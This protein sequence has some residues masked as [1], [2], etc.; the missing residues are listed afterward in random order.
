MVYAFWVR[1]ILFSYLSAWR[2]EHDRLKK[3]GKSAFS[4]HNEMIVNLVLQLGL[5]ALVWAFT[6]VWVLLQYFAA[7][8]IG[9]LLLETVNY[10][11]H[12]G[13][14]RQEKDGRPAPVLPVHSWNSNH[15]LG[16]VVLFE[17]TR[18][19]DHHYRPGRKY[20]VLRHMDGAPQMPAG[21]PAMIVLSLIPPLW[22]WIMHRQIRRFKETSSSAGAL[23]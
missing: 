14:R 11:E 19:S 9:V 2:L 1:S 3:A 15:V 18:H 21:Y 16:R 17:L 7:A 5:Y 20:Q 22:F 23:A 13:L 8:C 10:I 6:D 12:Y 4:I